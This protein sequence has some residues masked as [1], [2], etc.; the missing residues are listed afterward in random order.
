MTEPQQRFRSRRL[1]RKQERKRGGANA[2][3]L[4]ARML[5]ISD[6]D[7]LAKLEAGNVSVDALSVQ[8]E[9][10]AALINTVNDNVIKNN[11]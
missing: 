3:L 4:A 11:Q 6:P 1:I 5:A 8:I 2:G 10:L 9:G 7:I